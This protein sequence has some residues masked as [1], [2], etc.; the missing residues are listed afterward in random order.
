M[1]LFGGDGGKV[2][3]LTQYV[4]LKRDLYDC[5]KH[6]GY[7]GIRDKAGVYDEEYIKGYE[8]PIRQEYDW[9]EEDLYALPLSAAPEYTKACYHD[10]AR[11]HLVAK[12]TEL[13]EE[14]AKLRLALQIMRDDLRV[15]RGEPLM[16]SKEAA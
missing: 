2:R 12:I 1:W 8:V 4:L 16:T 14:N 6:M 9:Q 10:L 5:P 15:L 3:D 7:T 13:R 11:D